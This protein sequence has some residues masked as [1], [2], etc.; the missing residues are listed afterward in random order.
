MMERIRSWADHLGMLAV[1]ILAGSLVAWVVIE[2][3]GFPGLVM[4]WMGLTALGG[5]FIFGWGY[6]RGI[7]GKKRRKDA[8]RDGVR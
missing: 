3:P 2:N 5:A 8:S 1:M 4:A 6:G 7:I